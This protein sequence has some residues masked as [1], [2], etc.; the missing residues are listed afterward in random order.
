MNNKG[1]TLLE[2]LLAISMLPMILF[3]VGG[4]YLSSL[5]I[6]ESTKDYAEAHMDAQVVLMHIEKHIREAGSQFEIVDG[7]DSGDQTISFRIY[8]GSLDIPTV[9]S[10]YIFDSNEG[11]VIYIPDTSGSDRIIVGDHITDCSFST[12]STDGIVLHIDVTATDSNDNPDTS[13]TLSTYVEAWMTASPSVYT[14]S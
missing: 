6:Y 14:V 13:C 5:S 3:A 8:D 1:V 10:Q 4:F 9:T 11:Q 7:P 2:L 12:E